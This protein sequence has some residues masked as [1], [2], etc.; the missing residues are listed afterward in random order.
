MIRF[1]AI[2]GLLI[3]IILFAL[4]CSPGYDQRI[5]GSWGETTSLY[6]RCTPFTDSIR[7]HT[8]EKAWRGERI[9]KTLVLWADRG[10]PRD[11]R[12]K[13]SDLISESGDRIGSDQI[14]LRS[15][16]FVR[17]DKES[18]PCKGFTD[19]D[20]DEFVD[21]GDVL[22]PTLQTTLSPGCPNIYWYS[23]DIP[24]DIS[25]GMYTGTIRVD[26]EN[27]T[28][29]LLLT[30]QVIGHILPPV[31]Q[32]EFHL[33]LWQ[34]PC[35]VV[36][37]INSERTDD[38]ITYWSPE[39][40]RLLEKQYGLLAGM[41]QKVIT[42]HI[43]EGA[44]GSPSMIQ[45]IRH[46]GNSWSYDYT[47]F[48]LY[49]EMLMNLG[50]SAQISCQSPVGWNNH[51]LPYWCEEEGIKKEMA[52]TVG[53]EEFAR[54]WDHFL[55]DFRKHLVEKGW[56]SM[57]VLYLDEIDKDEL[58]WIISLIR[59]N[60]E[61]WKIGMAGFSPL[62]DSVTRHIHDLSMMVGTT[63]NMK[64]DKG[65][66]RSFYTSCNP[67]YPN[68]FISGGSDPADNIW[69]GWHAQH[70]GFH[71][72]L[73]WAF[74]YWT[75]SDPFEQRVGG[76]TSGDF[77]LCYRS[78]NEPDMEFFSSVRLEL[79]R[80]GIEDFEKIRYLKRV[81]EFHRGPSHHELSQQL[82]TVLEEFDFSSGQSDATV[83]Y[84]KNGQQVI[85]EISS[86]LAGISA[87]K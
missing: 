5:H 31:D 37:R 42:A 80:E 20:P 40:F 15:V 49:V 68:N 65:Q 22:N 67:P 38:L 10:D 1:Y 82:F 52:L 23:L 34:F 18:R 8:H 28:R 11:L 26:S 50:I 16:Q 56:F 41:G 75:V 12:L 54:R 17:A 81:L 44:L 84:I 61:D 24:Q 29:E 85:Q 73:R 74:D 32:W 7:T 66:N 71:G 55:H 62:S 78:S 43:K 33:D 79:L 72:F 60:H 69:I 77:S 70:L 46:R 47:S 21:L 64:W 30:L 63:G 4:T 13:F 48:D 51:S 76:F 59:N 45:W 2:P 6:E 57:A 86:R 19:R 87:I 14:Q 83:G 35:A 9:S 25:P 58:N 36:D 3:W 39:H 27:S 53:S